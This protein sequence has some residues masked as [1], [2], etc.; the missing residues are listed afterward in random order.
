M[1]ALK[2]LRL[3]FGDRTAL[4]LMLGTPFLLTLVISFAFG[5]LTGGTTGIESIPVALVNHDRG[6]FG[7]FLVEA[8]QSADLADLIAPT[9]LADEAAARAQVEADAI[10]AAVII[11]ANFSAVMLPAAGEPGGAPPEPAAGAAQVEVYANPA[12]PV[13]ASIIRAV[14]TGLLNQLNA[15]SVAG[16]TA[17]EGLV[18]AGLLDPQQAAEAAPVIGSRAGEQA[19]NTR[20]ISVRRETGAAGQFDPGEFDWAAYMAPSMA[21]MFLMFTVTAGS[22][23]ILAERQGGT[24]PR[25]LASPTHPGQVLGGKILGIFLIGV[26]QLAILAFASRVLLDLSWGDPLAVAALIAA[27]VFGATGWGVLLA[28]YARTPG[29]VSVTGSA[30]ALIFAGAAGNFVPRVNLP[31]WLRQI[32]L[33]SPNAW[34]LDGFAELIAGGRLTDILPAVGALAVMGVVLFA[35]AL[36]IFRRQTA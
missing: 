33:I 21:I 20:L 25:L 35:V 10:A 9:L 19:F 6:P 3:T 1:I 5:G 18:I 29:Q 24:L 28:A 32:S 30:L 15:S 14:A 11:P 8:F 7:Q 26:L 2:D 34:G 12:R 16:H 22:R 4:V 23:T 36:I 17:V 13:G 31:E 27:V